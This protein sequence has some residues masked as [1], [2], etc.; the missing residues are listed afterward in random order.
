MSV[1]SYL[2]HG[3]FR[4]AEAKVGAVACVDSSLMLSWGGGR[5][6]IDERW[7]RARARARRH[8]AV[9]DVTA[10]PDSLDEPSYKDAKLMLE[11]AVRR[12]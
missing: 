9:L 4:H 5:S 2:D 3:C 7:R 6:A 10:E 1:R 8:E 12:R 11:L